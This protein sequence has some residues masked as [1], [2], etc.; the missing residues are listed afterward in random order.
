MTKLFVV[1]EDCTLLTRKIPGLN[2]DKDNQ[3][4]DNKQ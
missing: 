2:K 3:V 4:T 1:R